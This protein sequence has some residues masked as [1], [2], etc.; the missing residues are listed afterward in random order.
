M[1]LVLI[2]LCVFPLFTFSQAKKVNP[3][4]GTGGHGHTFP[5]ACSPFGMVQLSP[6]TR[7]DGSWDGC[8]GYHYSDEY[9]Y[10]FSHT[11]LSGTGV[12]D[13]GDI[14]FLPTNEEPSLIDSVYK[15]KFSHNNEK[16]WAGFYHVDLENG[17]SCNLTTTERC[18]IHEYCFPQSDG[19]LL[20][21][22]IHRDEVLESEIEIL[23]PTKIRGKRISKAWA[24]EQHV[25]FVAE[26]SEPFEHEIYDH[27]DNISGA[28]I[29]NGKA[30]QTILNFKKLKESKLK[31]RIAL[32][33]T[34]YE[35]AEKNLAAE[36]THWDF[37][38]YLNENTDRWNKE[39]SK[40]EVHTKNKE[41]EEIFYSSLYHC[42]IHPS[43]ASDVDSSY[44]GRD[45]KI[46][47]ADHEVY[48][49]FSLWD[50][51][52]TLHPLLNIIDQKRSLDFI[53]T[54]LL[55]YEQG[56]RMPVW[57]LS[58]CE[59]ECMIGFHSVPVI[60]DAY[61]K[62]IRDFDVDL[63][64]KAMEASANRPDFGLEE[65]NQSGYL[66]LQMEHESVSKTLE[67]AYDMWVLAEF[68]KKTQVKNNQ[69]SDAASLKA[70]HYEYL[71]HAWKNLYNPKTGFIQP[72]DNGAWYEPFKPEEVNNFYTEANAWQYT[73]FVPHNIIGL[74]KTMGG[75]AAFENKLDQLFSTSSETS[76]RHQVDI[77]GLIGQYAHGNE[78]SH[79]MAYLYAFVNRPDKMQEKL[80][81]IMNE[82]YTTQPD[83]LIGNEDC[84]QMSAWYVMSSLGFYPVL[85]GS[86]TYITGLP[87]FDS[88]HIHLE[89]GKTFTMLASSYSDDKKYAST[90]IP[91]LNHNAI[92]KGGKLSFD[93]S[94]E[95][96][97]WKRPARLNSNYQFSFPQ[98]FMPAPSFEFESQV[99]EDSTLI[100]LSSIYDLDT[101]Y[102]IIYHFYDPTCMI[103]TCMHDFNVYNGPFYIKNSAQIWAYVR[104]K[105]DKSSGA[106]AKSYLHKRPNNWDIEINSTANP[107]YYAGGSLGLIDGLYGKEN[108]R[109][110]AWHGYQNQ[111]FEAVIDMK[112]VRTISSI[113]VSLLEDKRAWIFFPKE[114]LISY[115]Q[116]GE[117]WESYSGCFQDIPESLEQ[118]NLQKR[119]FGCSF[120]SFPKKARYVKI[121]AINY[122]K[123][124]AWHPGHTMDGDAFIFIDE[125]I[126]N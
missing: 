105:K 92:L 5:G 67:Y 8:G 52:R 86:P 76:G 47:K 90:K 82:F 80:Y 74:K 23:S 11:H 69:A 103:D 59:T 93:M 22:L 77:T 102:Q 7:I 36:A 61:V 54:F 17:I 15:Q 70:E 13:Y 37:R 38:R 35:G 65:F 87:Q 12:S 89:N 28:K 118:E 42:M 14:L 78:P 55:Q 104:N 113:Q 19:H 49:V 29:R 9:I 72:R 63:A 99:F 124:P 43:L 125:I 116:D 51:F 94:N 73:F 1:R 71:S 30:I 25:Y 20:I 114:L 88:A 97:S 34:G 18:G 32:S 121:K 111:D 109:A 39:L 46:H 96:K 27:K 115:S 50:T 107:Q 56:G 58:S 83:G 40:I 31:I 45:M 3:F 64:F 81:Q 44:R 41:K 123:L 119:N 16:A 84:G 108:W 24:N 48:T 33:Q 101:N 112:Q 98:R 126:V 106:M 120:S 68:A 57:E 21:D 10:G 2:F 95:P 91:M 110:G 26:F 79:H 117:I 122:G 100:T 53:K 6:D 85:P 60:L 66:N 4:I 75:K 62:G